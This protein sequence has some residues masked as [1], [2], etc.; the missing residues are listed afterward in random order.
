MD[1][2]EAF[3]LSDEVPSDPF[4]LLDLPSEVVVYILGFL[5]NKDLYACLQSSRPLYDC[6]TT[7]IELR[8]LMGMGLA[9]VTDNPASTLPAIDRLRMLRAREKA[10]KEVKPSWV[11]SIPVPFTTS[12]LYELSGGYFFLGDYDRQAV[13]YLELPSKPILEGSP[14]VV[15]GRIAPASPTSIIIDFGLAIQEHD[16][17]VIAT[18][19]PTGRII[20]GLSEGLI[21]LELQTMSTGLPHPQAQGTIEVR[22]SSWGRPNVI[23]EVVGDY[24]VF[25]EW[26]RLSRIGE[27][28]EMLP[29]DHVY[30]YEWRTGK[31]RMKLDAENG[32]YFAAVFVSP[33]VLLL[34]NTVTAALELWTIPS[35]Q[36]TPTLILHLPRLVPGQRIWIIS[37]R[38]EP[39]PSV[40]KPRRPTDLPFQSSAEDS[41]IIF[42]INFPGQQF[43]LFLH[44]R[45]LLALLDAHEPGDACS[46]A[47]WGPDVCRWLDAVGLNIDWI[48]TTSGQRSVL[49]LERSVSPF[50]LFD[51]N[52]SG[53][54]STLASEED[55]F[56]HHGIWAEAVGSRLK[57]H[58]QRGRDEFKVYS[59]VSLDDERVIAIRK[60][61]LRRV[62]AVDVFY[63]G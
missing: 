8:Y 50:F 21:N 41:I 6:I 58:V 62:T 28:R 36:T 16:L 11:S 49:L 55:P 19:K 4:R 43:L 5:P 7:S 34:P 32:T 30:V 15:W 35:E 25:V 37:A 52:V 17:V 12:G 46:Y 13:R 20:R 26:Y 42:H 3:D 60:N 38:G 47:Y 14:P 57:C 10:F 40:Y 24:L 63:F 29:D 53:P 23:L 18:F 39:N 33:D 22:T 27:Q 56:A 1:D 44:R 51:F 61:V 31:L 54:Q 45:A 59:G 9:R 2:S 48:T